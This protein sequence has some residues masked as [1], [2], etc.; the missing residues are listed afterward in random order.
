MRLLSML[1]LNCLNCRFGGHSWMLRV[2]RQSLSSQTNTQ[3]SKTWHPS[4]PTPS[5]LTCGP[6]KL[7]LLVILNWYAS[8]RSF[9]QLS[10]PSFL[11]AKLRHFNARKKN[12][13]HLFEIWTWITDNDSMR[14]V[15]P[16][17]CGQFLEPPLVKFQEE[18][19][20]WQDSTIKVSPSHHIISQTHPSSLKVYTFHM[21][22]F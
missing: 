6:A 8:H 21:F 22:F 9:E 1:L 3:S 11:D 18:I 5:F 2:C 4:P 10:L 14:K 7:E 13:Y 15:F 16:S 12:T 19:C 20:V 17:K